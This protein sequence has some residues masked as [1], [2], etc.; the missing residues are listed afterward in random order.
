MRKLGNL[1]PAFSYTSAQVAVM[2]SERENQASEGKSRNTI[3][4]GYFSIQSVIAISSQHAVHSI[5]QLGNQNAA[6]SY[7]AA[8]VT[9]MQSGREN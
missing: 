7:V 5:P 3:Q 1:R 2:G 8:K 4:D 9:V 6:S